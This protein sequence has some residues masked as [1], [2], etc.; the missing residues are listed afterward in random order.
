[1]GVGGIN[2][3]MN[4]GGQRLSEENRKVDC[5]QKMADLNPPLGDV[6]KKLLVFEQLLHAIWIKIVTRSEIKHL[7]KGHLVHT[8][9]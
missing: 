9:V 2:Y 6:N 4:V 7:S 3:V 1:M 8:R 5:F